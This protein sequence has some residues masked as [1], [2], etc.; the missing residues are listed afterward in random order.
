MKKFTDEIKTMPREELEF[1]ALDLW[2]NFMN[3]E[4]FLKKEL[5]EET[6]KA[7]CTDY[8]MEKSVA[9]LKD[10]DMTDADITDF[11]TFMNYIEE[12]EIK[13]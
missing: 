1:I 5:G 12:E 8:A 10:M 9:W 11:K 3:F 4:K 13:N 2:S 6:Y 7:L